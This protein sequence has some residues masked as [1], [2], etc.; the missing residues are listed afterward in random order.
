MNEDGARG[1]DWTDWFQ[2]REH[3]LLASL[4][5]GSLPALNGCGGGGGGSGTELYSQHRSPCVTFKFNPTLLNLD[6]A[7]LPLCT[8][9]YDPNLRA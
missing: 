1:K 7:L 6:P 9:S 2:G 8:T 4:A 3:D 5:V